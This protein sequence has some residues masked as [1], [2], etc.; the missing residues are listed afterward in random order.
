MSQRTRSVA[1]IVTA[2]AF[3]CIAAHLEA[4]T[5]TAYVSLCC[6]APSTAGVFNASTLAQTRSIATGSGGDGIA[7]TPDGTKLFVTVDIKRELQAIDA[8][9]GTIL[10]RV[11]VPINVS[12]EPPLELAI[13]PDGS[14]VYVFAPQDDPNA[15]LLEVDTTTYLVTHSLNLPFNESVGPL[16]VSPDGSQLYFE[17]GL[18]SEYIQVVDT[19]TL[20]PVKQI[21]VNE[22]PLWLTVTPSGLI[23]MTDTDNELLVIDPQAGIILNRFT[24]ASRTAVFS[25]AIAS[26]PDSTTAY[27]G[28]VG[29]SILAVNIT[30]GA[31]VF[32]APT[33]YN[34]S[35][36]A[37]SSNG[38]TLYS[39]NYSRTGTP[40]VSEFQ[41]PTQKAVA[42]VR[43]L[44]PLSGLALSHD[45]GTLYVLNADESA[46]ASVDVSS[47]KATGV[48]LGGVGINSLAIPANGNTV[49][50]SSYQF[51]AGGDI[52]ML[53]P[54]TGQLK[55]TFGP[56]GALAFSPS[57]TVLYV[58]NP[59]Q[60]VALDVQSMTQVAK[61]SAAQLQNIGQ[62]IPSPDG[63]RLYLSITFV[64]GGPQ[65]PQERVV[66]P[67]GD[68]AVL[69][70]S[71]LKRVGTINIPDGLGGMAL[72]SDGST[73]VCTS[74]K[75]HVHVID[76]ATDKIT[77]T[78]GLSP[79]NGLLESVALSSD[80]STAYVADAENNL[81]FVASL[82]TQT[83][84]AK[85]A[86]GKDPLNVAIT[87]DGSEAWVLTGAG[88]EIVNLATSEVGGPV[89]LPGSPSA[90]VFA[91]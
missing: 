19:A 91:P 29:P 63:T 21:P 1:Q 2:A 71:T 45:G 69:D 40:S 58:A 64:S 37:I 87:P 75:G 11:P 85:I 10:A 30:T 16:L 90:I 76:T 38:A 67:P 74:N 77:A 9:T 66:L 62:A 56:T 80:G 27:I 17:M 70:T 84:L 32:E 31:T 48:T 53:N 57:G 89:A 28:F 60:V 51:A 52:L 25:G 61:F 36:L 18:A 82:A 88:L 20:A 39:I 78:I 34:P 24:L 46:I 81:L 22:Y 15:E 47:R 41:I 86:V 72:T 42:T 83:Q 54:A 43:Q 26:S 14:R 5:P 33:S 49:W 6:N 68:I 4:S 12:G 79:A 23:L 35:Q 59:A 8:A 73:L 55:F 7:L 65:Q 50:A 13:S 44:G 3:L